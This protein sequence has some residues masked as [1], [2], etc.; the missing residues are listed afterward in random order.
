MTTF[1]FSA[2][3]KL[4]SSS[5][6][7]QRSLIAERVKGE[8]KSGYDFHKA[9]RGIC[10]GYLIGGVSLADSRVLAEAIVKEAERKSALTAIDRVA[11]WRRERVADA[12]TVA[13]RICESPTGIFKVRF[14]PD[15]GTTIDGQRVAIHL[16]NTKLPPLDA[17]LTRAALSLF[18]GLYEGLDDLAVLSLR[19]GQLVLLS[20]D[21]DAATIGANVVEALEDIFIEIRSGGTRPGAEEHPTP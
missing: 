1:G 19:N 7:R 21:A 16:W 11:A 3:L 8:R 6:K 14:D 2:F 18:P 20:E 5:A 10:G 12:F 17:R 9:M 4:V 13:S 15:F